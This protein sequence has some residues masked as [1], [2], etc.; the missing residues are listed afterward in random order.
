M[1][2]KATGTHVSAYAGYQ[3]SHSPVS[4]EGV[5]FVQFAE[6]GGAAR[7][8]KHTGWIDSES[9]NAAL[10]PA[11]LVVEDQSS[12]DRAP[13]EDAIERAGK[14][15]TV[16]AAQKTGSDQ[17]FGWDLELNAPRWTLNKDKDWNAVPALLTVAVAGA[18]AVLL[19]VI[20][21]DAL[22]GSSQ[23]AGLAV[24]ALAIGAWGAVVGLAFVAWRAFAGGRALSRVELR[25]RRTV[26][27]HIEITA[28]VPGAGGGGDAPEGA[29]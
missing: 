23:Q 20:L 12:E 16:L 15:L 10:S 5:D 13:I 22:E 1:T 7:F 17:P 11:A 28:G 2:W 14:A 3:P 9:L 26:P 18:I 27:Q 24:E 25:L 19:V 21:W 29:G 4:F 6:V 8:A